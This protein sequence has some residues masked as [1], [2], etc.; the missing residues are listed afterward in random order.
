MLSPCLWFLLF[1]QA[2]Q[3]SFRQD[4]DGC[5]TL[6]VCVLELVLVDL[7]MVVLF[8]WHIQS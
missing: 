4:S 5:F 8:P 2:F 3:S 7:S 1:F 6:F